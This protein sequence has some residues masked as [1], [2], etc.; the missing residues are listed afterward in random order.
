MNVGRF[1]EELEFWQPDPEH[2]TV[3]QYGR[4]TVPWIKVATMKGSAADVSGRDYW[5]AAAHQLQHT[6]TFT[7]RWHSKV[8]ASC[9]VV[10]QG[11]TY[12]IDQVNHLGY[13]R[14]FMRVK[15]H[16]IEAVE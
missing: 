8:D 14:D 3:D 2:A 11:E 9:R 5:D 6:I 1:T 16:R 15:A 10:W 4:R 12:Q 7:M 13:R